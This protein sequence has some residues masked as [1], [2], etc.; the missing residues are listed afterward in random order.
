[1]LQKVFDILPDDIDLSKGGVG[2]LALAHHLGHTLVSG[3][4]GADAIDSTGKL[5]E[6]KV[7]IADRYNFHFGARKTNVEDI[8]FKHFDSIEG[9]YC[10]KRMGMQIVDIV[11][12][13][14]EILVPDLIDHFNN[15]TGGQMVKCYSMKS[16]K[17][18]LD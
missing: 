11:Y 2:E 14:S 1:M 3:D 15:T 13:P 9:A 8:V 17:S 7:S 4:K 12:I 18:L 6:Y 16:V 5:Y 10:A